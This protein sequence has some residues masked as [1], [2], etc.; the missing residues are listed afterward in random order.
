MMKMNQL[1]L[2]YIVQFYLKLESQYLIPV[3]TIDHL[4]V[5]IE[6]MH[7]YGW[8]NM[9]NNI[10]QFLK[11]EKISDYNLNRICKHFTDLF[12]KSNKL[13][14]NKFKRLLHAQQKIYIAEKNNARYRC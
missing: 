12:L 6:N 1:F 13:L 8:Q 9:L 5:D 11:L 2:T 10:R 4:A 3:S 14:N 7:N